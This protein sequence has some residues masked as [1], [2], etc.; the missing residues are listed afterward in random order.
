MHLE[1]LNSVNGEAVFTN[2]FERMKTRLSDLMDYVVDRIW[3]Q[4]PGPWIQPASW[5][6]CVVATLNL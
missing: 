5:F 3:G 6:V 2:P 4:E 1:N